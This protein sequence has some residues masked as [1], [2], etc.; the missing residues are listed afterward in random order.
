MPK[1]PDRLALRLAY[2]AYGVEQPAPL[3]GAFQEHG[4]AVGQHGLRTGAGQFHAKQPG[5]ID[6]P[7]NRDPLQLLPAQSRRPA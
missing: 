1:A 3:P 5:G 2:R 6:V 4:E 7:G